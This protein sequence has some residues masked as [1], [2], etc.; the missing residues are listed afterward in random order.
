[1]EDLGK[2][3]D[4]SIPRT[5]VERKGRDDREEENLKEL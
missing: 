5:R 2:H 1:M 4:C 3:G